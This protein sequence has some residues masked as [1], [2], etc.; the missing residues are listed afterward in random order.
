M[1]ELKENL[2]LKIYPNP[3]KESATLEIKDSGKSSMNLEMNIYDV[4]GRTVQENKISNLKSQIKR[5][6][7]KSG[8]Y[9]YKI[10]SFGED[11][12]RNV[13]STGKLCIE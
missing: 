4:F 13:V 9:F 8:I 12:R 3:F 11:G 10:I 6:N 7:L 5:E 2:S 1:H